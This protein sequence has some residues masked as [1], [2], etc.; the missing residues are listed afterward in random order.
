MRNAS[1]SFYPKITGPCKD[2]ISSRYV[3]LRGGES[4]NARFEAYLRLG[5][6]SEECQF[7]SKEVVCRYLFPLCDTSLNRP[8]AQGI[9]RKSCQ[10]LDLWKVR[11]RVSCPERNCGSGNRTWFWRKSNQLHYIPRCQWRRGT[12]MLPT[13]CITRWLLVIFPVAFSPQL[14]KKLITL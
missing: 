8:L 3:Y 12:R 1:C 2:I 10:F 9:C 5:F 6:I 13:P 14:F 7:F 4:L 11:K